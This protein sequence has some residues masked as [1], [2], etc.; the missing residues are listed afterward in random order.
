MVFHVF[1]SIAV[2]LVIAI[3]GG[4]LGYLARDKMSGIDEKFDRLFDKMDS[5]EQKAEL[6]HR[7][8]MQWLMNLTENAEGV[9]PPENV[10]KDVSIEVDGESIDDLDFVRG[11]SADTENKGS[12]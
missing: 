6:R 3:V 5:I 12:D 2:G 9:H 4:T 1:E 7:V 11:G 10:E 8:M